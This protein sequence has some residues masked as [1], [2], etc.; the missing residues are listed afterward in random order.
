MNNELSPRQWQ[1]LSAY[2][3]DQLTAKEKRRV[4]EL[5][6]QNPEARRA[7][8]SLRQTRAAL[9]AMPMHKAPRNFTLSA[10]PAQ[11]PS[12][13]TFTAV[14][15]YS[16]ALAA[17]LLVVV[18]VLDFIG[19]ASPPAVNRL[20]ADQ[21]QERLAME[22]PAQKE[23]GQPPII[24]W[25]PPALGAYGKGGGGAA[26]AAGIGGG[27]AEP[28]T[29]APSE[30]LPEALPQVES[31]PPVEE[32]TAPTEGAAQAQGGGEL[33]TPEITPTPEALTGSGPI[34]GVQPSPKEGEVRLPAGEELPSQ[35][36]R[37]P[38]PLS[39]IEIILAVLV[40][41]LAVPAWL[42]RRK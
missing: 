13:P 11:I 18:L 17:T 6:Q 40:V 29:A 38:V 39:T 3:D 34:L 20:A 12:V 27:A 14:L 16:S 33:P 37:L 23:T 22:A 5:L 41:V 36:F 26:P 28:S 30:P 19:I 10:K 4:D 15:R 25:G 31:M 21:A 8:D 35:P 32:Q 1:L 42:L 24:M 7:L 2:L 9:R